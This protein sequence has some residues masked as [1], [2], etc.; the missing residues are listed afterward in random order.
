MLHEG[1]D[2]SD[3]IRIQTLKKDFEGTTNL[4]VIEGSTLLWRVQGSLR[5]SEIEG[6]SIPFQHVGL[7]HMSTR[8]SW[9]LLP[10]AGV[11]YLRV[12]HPKNNL[13]KQVKTTSNTHQTNT[14]Q[15]KQ[16]LLP[17]SGTLKSALSFGCP[18]HS[19]SLKGAKIGE[20]QGGSD[21]FGYTT[22]GRY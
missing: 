16:H 7:H 6:L 20:S 14:E 13:N 22:Q 11:G 12:G 1:G 21:V 18:G 15:F 8:L 2:I 19:S 17:T 4:S 10:S 9:C 5:D 3:P